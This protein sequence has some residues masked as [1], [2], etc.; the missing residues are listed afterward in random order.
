MKRSFIGRLAC[1]GKIWGMYWSGAHT[2]HRLLYHLVWVPK[3]RRRILRGKIAVR[4]KELFH[5]ACA[6][7]EWEI[8]EMEVMPDHIHMLIQIWPRESV[9]RVV[10]IL[11]GGSSYVL[12]GEFAEFAEF[13][14]G[15]SFWADGYF[16]ETVG[17]TNEDIIRRYIRE[18]RQASLPL[19][20]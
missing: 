4:V 7:N 2:K 13:R 12:R 9:S 15:K 19:S 6:V 1:R 16:A 8:E 17:K 18:Q 11:K 14:W 10:Q 5:E 3:Y 20:P